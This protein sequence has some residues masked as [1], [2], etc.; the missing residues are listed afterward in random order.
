[1]G[2]PPPLVA[3]LAPE[4]TAKHLRMWGPVADSLGAPPL[5]RLRE[6]ATYEGAVLVGPTPGVRL[7]LHH[8][9]QHGRPWIYW[10]R[11]YYARFPEVP[12]PLGYH[13]LTLNG[14]QQSWVR[15]NCDPHRLIHIAS[16]WGIPFSPWQRN[17]NGHILL[18]A[19]SQSY[20]TF[21]YLGGWVAE[22]AAELAKRTNRPVVLREKGDP[23]PLSAAL[24][25]CYAVVTHGSNVAVE[26]AIRG[27]PVFVSEGSA[28]APIGRTSLDDI[29]RPAY[30]DRQE[31]LISLSYGQFTLSEMVSG[32]AWS[33]IMG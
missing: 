7:A 14:F 33:T 24:E 4:L 29:E 19:P 11:G 27:T 8:R 32:F 18:C 12:D 23:K 2:S 28:A 6:M 31:W 26:A 9:T 15:P 16:Q 5:R 25:G 20:A 22:T 30:P 3:Y 10:D 17:P 21:H 13:R 1:M